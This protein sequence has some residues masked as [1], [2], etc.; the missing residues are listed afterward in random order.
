L[1]TISKRLEGTKDTALFLNVFVYLNIS[2][3]NLMINYIDKFLNQNSGK[4]VWREMIS[5]YTTS[6]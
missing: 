2:K 4:E 3:F 5:I 1:V 6:C